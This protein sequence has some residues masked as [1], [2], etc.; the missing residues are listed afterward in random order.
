LVDSARHRQETPRP[1]Q[2]IRPESSIERRSIRTP[3]VA[4]PQ[5]SRPRSVTGNVTQRASLPRALPK[6]E[7]SFAIRCKDGIAEKHVQ[8]EVAAEACPA[9][10]GTAQSSTWSEDPVSSFQWLQ[11]LLTAGCDGQD[12]AGQD[13]MPSDKMQEASHPRCQAGWQAG[14]QAGIQT[15]SPCGRVD[16]RSVGGHAEHRS[17]ACGSELKA[18]H[19]E[20]VTSSV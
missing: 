19:K 11:P 16:E 1:G 6:P 3:L 14:W 15:A 5:T 8:A 17:M 12:A 4:K 9:P 2:I 20:S 10:H 18:Q 7:E 13:I